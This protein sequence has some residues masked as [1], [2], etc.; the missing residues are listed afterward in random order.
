MENAQSNYPNIPDES[1]ISPVSD[2]LRYGLIGGLILVIFSFTSIIFD[3]HLTSM[4]TA[5][6]LGLAVYAIV[7]ILIIIGAKNHRDHTLGGYISFGRA[8]VTGTM[9]GLLASIVSQIF[10]IIYNIIDPEYMERITESML[11]MYEEQGLNEQQLEEIADRMADPNSFSNI[12][13]GLM[14]FLVLSAIV[15]AI[16]AAVIKKEKPRAYDL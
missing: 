7:I 16:V 5:I 12:I 9:I 15:A 6:L 1:E 4:M 10:N 2:I 8:F 3:L 13:T 14:T 11:E